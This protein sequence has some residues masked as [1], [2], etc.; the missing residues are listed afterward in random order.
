M[1]LI[2][3]F[4][5]LIHFNVSAKDAAASYMDIATF[6]K[7]PLQQA[8]PSKA[9]ASNVELRT[10]KQ[11][12][13]EEKILF[14]GDKSKAT[15]LDVV[16]KDY[17]KGAAFEQTPVR[18]KHVDNTLWYSKSEGAI[19]ISNKNKNV[20]SIIISTPARTDAHLAENQKPCKYSK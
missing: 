8:T 1:L 4:L 15:S 2:Y 5:A 14:L 16:L 9:L 18:C 20:E 12:L 13:V 7:I 6:K 3:I 11:G 19:I 17:F 10:D